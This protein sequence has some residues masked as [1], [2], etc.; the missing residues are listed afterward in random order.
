MFQRIK[1]QLT[2]NVGLFTCVALVVFFFPRQML[3]APDETTAVETNGPPDQ[4]QSGPPQQS[5]PTQD[6]GAATS[7]HLSDELVDE[8]LRHLDSAFN[9]MRPGGIAWVVTWA[10]GSLQRIK[11]RLRH[12]GYGEILVLS[13]RRRAEV[14]FQVSH[15]TGRPY[16]NT[17]SDSATRYKMF[18]T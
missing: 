2:V 14:P 6:N 5:G 16:R 3:G 11:F 8:K 9:D 12:S 18:W 17:F 15:P 4:A 13:L 7:D 1:K 10:V